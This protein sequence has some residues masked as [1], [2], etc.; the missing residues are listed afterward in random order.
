MAGGSAPEAEV[1]VRN[2]DFSGL[3]LS[4]KTLSAINAA[5]ASF[6]GANLQNAI[7][8]RIYARRANFKGANLESATLY[9]AQLQGAD[10]RDAS[11]ANALMST[12]FLGKDEGQA[13]VAAHSGEWA[14][15]AGADLDAIF[16]RS[17]VRNLCENPTLTEEQREL[18]LGC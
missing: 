8:T 16:S 13:N 12:V 15:M 17:D 9:E 1:D 2:C 18:Q 5:G 10:L 7:M 4:G 11:L 3:D 6:E 14:Q